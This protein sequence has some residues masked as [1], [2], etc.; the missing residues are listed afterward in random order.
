VLDCFA[1]VNGCLAR[2]AADPEITRDFLLVYYLW[3]RDEIM[4]PLRGARRIAADPEGPAGLVG[5][6]DPP[7]RPG[8]AEVAVVT[9]P[10]VFTPA[11][12]AR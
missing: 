5:P 4:D 1:R 11:P 6:A 10:A 7:R 3:W 8:R 12:A 2:G 9:G